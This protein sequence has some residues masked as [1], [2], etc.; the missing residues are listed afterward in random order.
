MGRWESERRSKG[1]GDAEG[2]EREGGESQV[3]RRGRF[4][5]VVSF[6]FFLFPFSFFFIDR[7]EELVA[8]RTSAVLI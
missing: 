6:T 7:Y 3:S 4:R 1:D 5:P 2:G 8:D